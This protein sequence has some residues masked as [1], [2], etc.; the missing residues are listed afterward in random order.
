MRASHGAR[1]V[2]F[3]RL[4]EH[5]LRF[6]PGVKWGA[7]A[8]DVLPASIAD[9]DFPVAEPIL[10]SL[11]GY[12][13]LG[14]LG[15]PN[16]T[17]NAS[18]LREAFAQ[19]MNARY[20][21]FPAAEHVRE[22]TDVTHAVRTSLELSTRPGDGVAIHTPAFG[23][24]P[25][26]IR[27]LGL[28]MVPIPM[29]DTPEGW[30][31]DA[32]DFARRVAREGCRALILVNPH[33]PTGRV[34]TRAELLALGE[35]AERHDLTVISDDLHAD[36][37]YAP[38]RHVPFASIGSALEARTVTLYGASKAY[39]LAGMRCAVGHVGPVALREKLAALPAGPNVNVLG[40]RASLAAWTEASDWLDTVVGYLDD[41]RRLIAGMLAERLPEVRYHLPEATYLAWL[42]CRALGCGDNP[43]GY[44]LERARVELAAGTKYNPGGDGFVRLNFGTAT[45]VLRAILDR[46]TDSVATPRRLA[47]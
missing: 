19:R 22:F 43:A 20:D 16:W 3:D 15:Y 47:S 2:V 6:R 39:N 42:D 32:E 46:M 37:T 18:P 5:T 17:D 24:F 13:D 33:N 29:L 14:D 28:R 7:P 25:A 10:A 11:R 35:V 12:L 4:D 1:Y 30:V 21:W 40:M 26:M 36:L 34:F 31:F 44:F 9:M 38:H 8:P 45:P 27:Q 41:N 23:P